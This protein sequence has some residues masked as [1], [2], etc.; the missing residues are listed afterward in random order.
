MTNQFD[1]VN[2][3]TK[4]P[5]EITAGDFT[6]WKRTDLGDFD[7][8]LHTLKYSARLG[9][10]GSTEIEITA[11]A[12]GSDYLVA[13]PSATSAAYVVGTYY[14]QL[15]ITRDADS[16]RIHI[17]S[18]TWKVGANLDVATTDPRTHARIMLDKIESLLENRADADVADYSIGNRSITK[19]SPKELRDWRAYYMNEVRAEDAGTARARGDTTENTILVRF[20]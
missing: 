12:D 7:N 20:T 6:Q 5:S 3:P 19:M 18:D 10:T 8:T 1:A 14:W 15:Y 13:I 9:G 11:T 4:E 16:E 2:A 17:D